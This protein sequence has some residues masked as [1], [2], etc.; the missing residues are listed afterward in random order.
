M[1]IHQGLD[2]L[3][4]LLTLGSRVGLRFVFGFLEE[5]IQAAHE[6]LIALLSHGLAW[7]SARRLDPVAVTW[8]LMVHVCVAFAAGPD[9]SKLPLRISD[10]VYFLRNTR[11]IR[12]LHRMPFC[13]NR[14][15]A[16]SRSP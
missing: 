16:P 8:L 15:Q 14:G 3:D 6:F 12:R 11:A 5:V 1:A 2:L 7:P 10:I 9:V 13:L 4:R